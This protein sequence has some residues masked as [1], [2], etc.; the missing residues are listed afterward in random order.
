MGRVAYFLPILLGGAFLG[1]CEPIDTTVLRD[2]E[3]TASTARAAADGMNA[4]ATQVQEAMDDPAGA[5][6]TATLGATFAKTR[7][8]EPNLFVLTDLQTGCQWLATYGPAGE[9]SSIAPRRGAGG[10]QR[11]IAMAVDTGGTP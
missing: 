4:N 8:A 9:A 10:R 11:S 3:E 1:A 2:I 7:T 6:R 5:L